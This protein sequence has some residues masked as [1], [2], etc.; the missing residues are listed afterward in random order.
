[1]G[2]NAARSMSDPALI[3][4]SLCGALAGAGLGLLPGLH[5]YNVAGAL[6]LFAAAS[7]DALPPEALGMLMIGLVVGWAMTSALP[8]VFL[9]AP[10]D[11][12]AGAILPATR[13]LLLGRG[14]EASLLIGAGSL[15]ALVALV[16]LAP[17]LDGLFRPLR[18]ILQEHTPWMLCAVIAFLLLG[19]WPRVEATPGASPARRLARAWAYLGAGLLT[20][21][22][23]GLIGFALMTRSPIPAEA[24]FQNLMPAF[25]GLFAL[26]GLIQIATFGRRIPAQQWPTGLP[27]TPALWAR[28]TLTGLAGGLFA[29]FVPVISGGIGG[30]LAGHASAERDERAFLIS[31]GASKIVY[32]V[33]SLLLLFIPGLS[34]TRGG[35]AWM[36]S[37]LYIPHGWRAFALSVAAAALGG[38]LSFWVLLLCARALSRIAHTVN[39]IAVAALAAALSLAMVAAFTGPAGL[40]VALAATPVGL[41][42]VFVGGRRLN[43]LGVV[44]LPITLN[45]VGLG[46][47]LARL[48][49]LA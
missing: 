32:Y 44:L 38:A 10:D 22:L 11:A 33:G 13:A 2:H 28:A 43:T 19:E 8:T 12:G 27:I 25:V 41:I 21:V 30:L 40:L 17:L 1:M 6:L 20:F 26:P 31:Q 45:A 15:A 46:P 48:L 39:P 47:W 5:V 34:L 16:A 23:S 9:F 35:M 49:G 14:A 42:P 24:A 4:L 18:A 29:A 36:L 7:P 3:A 37:S